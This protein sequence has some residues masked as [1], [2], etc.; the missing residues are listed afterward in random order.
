[1]YFGRAFGRLLHLRFTLATCLLYNPRPPTPSLPTVLS[2]RPS[3]R[4][5]APHVRRSL[6][7]LRQARPRRRVSVLSATPRRHRLTQCP[8]P[9]AEPTA[10]TTA[11]LRTPSLRLSLQQ[12]AHNPRRSSA[13]LTM[14]PCTSRRSLHCFRLPSDNHL[15]RADPPIAYGTQ[16][17][18][19]PTL[20]LAGLLSTTS[21]KRT[22]LP[23]QSTARTQ[24][25]ST[26][27][28]TRSTR[29]T[30]PSC[31]RRSVTA[32]HTTHPHWRTCAAL[33]RPIIGP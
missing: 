32:T 10:P 6:S 25:M 1:M 16:S 7:R 14:R 15:A 31:P 21:T 20:Q 28:S 24:M 12:A 4:P 18:P 22:A 5:D 27:L 13:H 2:T 29:R 23:L 26:T 17:R 3:P 11:R 8:S 9:T 33:L 19:H 30:H